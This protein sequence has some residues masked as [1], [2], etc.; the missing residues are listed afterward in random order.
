MPAGY[1][2]SG[3]QEGG[4]LAGNDSSDDDVTASRSHCLPDEPLYRAFGDNAVRFRLDARVIT[5]P[6][7]STP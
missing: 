1:R 4:S 2:V 7:P 3:V 6:F 5:F